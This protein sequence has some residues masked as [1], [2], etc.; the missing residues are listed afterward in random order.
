MTDELLIVGT[1]HFDPKG[2][3]RLE[4]IIGLY[5]PDWVV[6]EATQ[7]TYQSAL[8]GHTQIMSLSSAQID[9]MK[10][11]IAATG[12]KINDKTLFMVLKTA[13]Y[14]CWTPASISG[15][16]VIPGD[17]AVSEQ[18]GTDLSQKVIK[19]LVDP[20]S[21][22]NLYQDPSQWQRN[23]DRMYFTP[24]RLKFEND[25]NRNP[26]LAEAAKK[27]G[28]GMIVTGLHHAVM[29]GKYGLL[30]LLHERHPK[31]IR[32]VFADEIKGGNLSPYYNK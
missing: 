9:E 8:S 4:K 17:H 6:V 32:L 3:K 7:A 25:E 23:M 21:S 10:A 20:R 19:E 27:S 28:K 1:N 31:Y 2:P 5:K 26:S 29:V 15:L 22:L 30:N 13:G 16:E 18:M 24:S 11:Q 12:K 14:E